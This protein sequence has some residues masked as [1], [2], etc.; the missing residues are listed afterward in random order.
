MR[1]EA[2]GGTTYALGPERHHVVSGDKMAGGDAWHRFSNTRA[3]HKTVIGRYDAANGEL[4][5][6]QEFNTPSLIKENFLAP[7]LCAC[8]KATSP[9]MQRDAC[10]TGA[11]AFGLPIEFAPRFKKQSGQAEFNPFDRT[12]RY[13]AVSHGDVAGLY[14]PAVY[15]APAAQRPWSYR[16]GSC[17]RSGVKVVWGVR[18]AKGHRATLVAVRQLPAGQS[19]G[20][21]AMLGMAP[22]EIGAVLSLKLLPKYSFGPKNIAVIS[23]RDVNG[24]GN[25]DLTF[26]LPY[27]DQR[28]VGQSDDI[29][30]HAG[31]VSQVTNKS[32]KVNKPLD[33]DNGGRL[34][35]SAA[36]KHI[37]ITRI[38]PKR[39][40]FGLT[41][42]LARNGNSFGFN[43][44]NTAAVTVSNILVQTGSRL[45]REGEQW[46]IAETNLKNEKLMY[47][48]DAEDGRWAPIDL[49]A[50]LSSLPQVFRSLGPQ[51]TST[52]PTG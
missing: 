2:A 15:H 36:R 20:F 26:C 42:D 39:A 31:F 32:R 19:D 28:P 45:V 34:G 44:S 38:R 51:K 13:A 16:C 50:A 1:H 29:S 37:L 40:G 22:L 8:M 46:Y 52:R 48:T 6:I 33:L 43:R 3:S 11:A 23:D 49:A 18:L 25:N 9:R 17:H 35:L 21:F 24:D 27:D 7:T 47:F 30:L 41:T 12:V 10:L 4:M 5:R 14:A